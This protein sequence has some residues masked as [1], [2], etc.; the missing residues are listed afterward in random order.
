M[1]VI[2]G[3]GKMAELIWREIIQTSS[4]V[5]CGGF[6][7]DSRFIDR[8]K[9]MGLQVTPFEEIET[10]YPPTVNHMITAV[11]Y[12]DMY[13][14]EAMFDKARDKGYRMPGYWSS[15]VIIFKRR[16]AGENNIIFGNVY[17]SPDVVMGHNNVIRPMTYVGHDVR[18]GYHNFIGPGVTLLGNCTIGDRCF[19]GGG[20]TISND[21]YIA[22]DTVIGAGSV[23]IRNTERDGKYVG[24][25]GR[26]I[27]G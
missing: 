9:F 23:I 17:V 21:V 15:N 25:P 18:I 14:R 2:Y 22:D 10:K 8:D 3:I 20:A 11:G 4:L 13:A 12:D 1:L 19:I 7:A 27:N 16:L 6:T 26:R 5:Q 24:N